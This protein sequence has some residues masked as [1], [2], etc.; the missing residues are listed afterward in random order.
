MVYCI[1]TTVSPVPPSRR[2]KENRY[3]PGVPL[4]HQGEEIS[5]F[6][7][8]NCKVTWVLNFAK[9]WQKMAK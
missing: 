9:K 2:G 5:K 6:V 3:F 4:S 1:V 8:P 7:P